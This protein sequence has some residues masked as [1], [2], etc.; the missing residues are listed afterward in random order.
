MDTP[1]GS[2]NTG[3]KSRKNEIR[4]LYKLHFITSK[5]CYTDI[6][7]YAVREVV[8]KLRTGYI[9]LMLMLSPLLFGGPADRVVLPVAEPDGSGGSRTVLWTLDTASGGWTRGLIRRFKPARVRNG[10]VFFFINNYSKKVQ[11]APSA[12]IVGTNWQAAPGRYG[13][14]VYRTLPGRIAVKSFDWQGRLRRSCLVPNPGGETYSFRPAGRLLVMEHWNTAGPSTE[15]YLV[16]PATGRTVLKLLRPG[17]KYFN[18]YGADLAELDRDRVVIAGNNGEVLLRYNTRTRRR[19]GMLQLIEAN[20]EAEV[21]CV[22]IV[23]GRYRG[24]L[25]VVHGMLEYWRDGKSGVRPAGS[26]SVLDPLRLRTVR[27]FAP[28]KR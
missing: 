2:F 8:M 16:D 18:L 5:P 22:R 25:A 14:V 20:A 13:F 4:S 12:G 3:M 7:L 17:G 28:P 6:A 1:A 26:V 15:G 23:S 24:M 21:F 10:S 19:T 11:T 9:L 27:R